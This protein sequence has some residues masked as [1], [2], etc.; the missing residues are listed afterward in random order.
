[1]EALFQTTEQ[2]KWVNDLRSL[3]VD[4]KGKELE[5]LTE[6]FYV[7]LLCMIKK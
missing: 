3:F 6:M 4:A 5:I 2:K 7:D 1:M